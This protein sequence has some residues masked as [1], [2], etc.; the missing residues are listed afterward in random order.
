MSL[1][2]RRFLTLTL[3]ATLSLTAAACG[4]DDDDNN[5]NNTSAR[6]NPKK[7]DATA[8]AAGQA[9]YTGTCDVCHSADGSGGIGTNLQASVPMR[10]DAYLY[11]AIANGLGNGSMPS[12]KGSYSEDQIWELVSYLQSL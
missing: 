12:Y 3:I 10:T 9:T 1:T 5:A 7:G 6:T 4:G 8:I 2:I 11:D